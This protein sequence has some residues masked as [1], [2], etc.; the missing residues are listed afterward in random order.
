VQNHCAGGVKRRNQ[1]A[2]KHSHT[3]PPCAGIHLHVN[4][5]DIMHVIH[6]HALRWKA[7]HTMV[8]VLNQCCFNS[9]VVSEAISSLLL[10]LIWFRLPPVSESDPNSITS[11]DLSTGIEISTSPR[12]SAPGGALNIK[13]GAAG[14]WSSDTGVAE[15]SKACLPYVSSTAPLCV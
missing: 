13:I 12:N 9:C 15:E 5:S 11:T 2:Q 7:Q 6:A 4:L 1:K 10:P 14:T 8:A 3:L